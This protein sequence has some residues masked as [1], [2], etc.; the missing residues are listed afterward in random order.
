MPICVI[1]NGMKVV[2]YYCPIDKV[3]SI[4]KRKS[5]NLC[6]YIYKEITCPA[7]DGKGSWKKDDY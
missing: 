6:G 5:C 3:Y 4:S 1:C 7:C 2:T